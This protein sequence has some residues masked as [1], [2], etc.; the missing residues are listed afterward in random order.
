MATAEPTTTAA[1]GGKGTNS[2]D[3]VPPKQSAAA[4]KAKLS[5]PKAPKL[6]TEKQVVKDI[7]KKGMKEE[8]SDAEKRML[9]AALD[10]EKPEVKNEAVKSEEGKTD[11]KI[12]VPVGKAKLVQDTDDF[13][14]VREQE[15][16]ASHSIA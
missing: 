11:L 6:S 16:L 3:K 13:E 1:S 7:L 9:M 5:A 14:A 10:F 8:L 4:P 2:K 12:K 15:Q